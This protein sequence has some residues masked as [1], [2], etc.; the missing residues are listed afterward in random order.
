MSLHAASSP[1]VNGKGPVQCEIL[2]SRHSKA[3]INHLLI[4][5]HTYNIISI[6]IHIYQ[7]T[8][9]YTVVKA[10]VLAGG[11]GKGKYVHTYILHMTIC[12]VGRHNM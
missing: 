6:Y 5:I 9:I 3:T 2:K 12:R 11:R 8:Y 1:V 4:N 7:Y 10:Q